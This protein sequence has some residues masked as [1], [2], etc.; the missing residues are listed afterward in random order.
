VRIEVAEHFVGDLT[1]AAR[2]H[3]AADT[4]ARGV[5]DLPPRDDRRDHDRHPPRLL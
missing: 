5:Y 4:V 3:D 1:L 2:L